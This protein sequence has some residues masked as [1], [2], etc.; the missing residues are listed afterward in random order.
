[1]IL[2]CPSCQSRYVVPDSA[3]GVAGR[4]V[5]CANCRHSW[6]QEG[7]PAAPVPPAPLAQPAVPVAE[8]TPPTFASP[9]LRRETAPAR[10]AVLGDTAAEPEAPSY[11][12]FAAEP[13][14]RPRR[15]PAKMWTI[16]AVVAALLMT[17]AA[18]A[19]HYF[20]VPGFGGDETASSG[21][22]GTPLEIQGD[23][24][25][26]PLASGGILLRVSGRISNPSDQPQR[27]PQIQAEL[28]DAQGRTVHSWLIAPPVTELAPGQAAN[29]N[30]AEI[31]PE[32]SRA[33]TNV[34]LTFAD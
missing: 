26:T 18:L 14:F 13:P 20:G 11:D 24:A 6:F 19:V 30:S 4:Q 22:S 29:I 12:A 7:A 17:A 31:Q 34:V 9:P 3:I 10:S 32:G 1:M 8:P 15:N 23:G 33:A 27:V 25:R 2:S 5:R 28:K 21:E 16:I